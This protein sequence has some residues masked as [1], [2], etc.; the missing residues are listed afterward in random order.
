MQSAVQA[1]FLIRRRVAS[2]GSFLALKGH[3]SPAYFV[4]LFDAAMKFVQPT[5][6]PGLA[7]TGWLCAEL[8]SYRLSQCF[9]TCTVL[10]SI[11]RDSWVG[12]GLLTG[13]WVA[14]L[15]RIYDS[16]TRVQQYSVPSLLRCSH[17]GLSLLLRNRVHTIVPFVTRS[18]R[19]RLMPGIRT[20]EG[21][22]TAEACL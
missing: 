6:V 15:P 17:L 20:G 16:K 19:K 22:E 8:S 10:Y 21:F 7:R 13:Y 12:S 3:R 4:L 1:Q 5:P 14:Q 11:P 2:K 18:A 9:F